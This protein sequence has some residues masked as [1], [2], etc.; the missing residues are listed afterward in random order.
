[1]KIRTAACVLALLLSPS[2]IGRSQEKQD[3][4]SKGVPR[5]SIEVT[6]YDFGIVKPG[7]PLKH[8]FMFKNEGAADLLI[9]SVSPG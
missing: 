8:P 2:Q 1:M 4:H 7:T 3:E 9:Q 6:T 5:L